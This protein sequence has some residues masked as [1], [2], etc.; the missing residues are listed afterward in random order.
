M[1]PDSLILDIDGTLWDSTGIVADAWNDVVR[2]RPD[3][4]VRFTP[5]RLKEL[6]GKTLDRIA[7]LSFP[8][9]EPEDR[10]ELI[11]ICCERE[12]ESIRASSQDIL[13]PGVRETVR[14]LSGICPL[15]IVSNCQAGYIELFLEKTGLG[16]CIR[17]FECP[18][19][20]GLEKG[21]NIRLVADRNHLCSP[22]YVGDTSGD[23]KACAAAGIPFCHASYGF[24]Y[25]EAPEYTIGQF[26]DLLS[27]F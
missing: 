26:S 27:F 11:R 8:F 20:T 21:P 2:S 5:Q 1:K 24:G 4:P 14:E 7:D 12:H 22:V 15:F 18:G 19:Y 16:P 3:V 9:L 10:Y 6:F 25:A 13:Y 17:D 23:Q